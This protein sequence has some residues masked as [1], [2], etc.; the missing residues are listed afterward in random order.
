MEQGALTEAAIEKTRALNTEQSALEGLAAGAC[1]VRTMSS[2]VHAA[3]DP[4][5]S[6][7]RLGPEVLAVEDQAERVDAQAARET[8]RPPGILRMPASR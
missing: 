4:L 2:A 6:N 7:L 5:L 8:A 1:A 3:I